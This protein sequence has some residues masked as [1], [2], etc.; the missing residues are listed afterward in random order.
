MSDRRTCGDCV[1]FPTCEALDASPS[2]PPCDFF[3]AARFDG[4][5]SFAAVEIARVIDAQTRDD[6]VSHLADDH[7]ICRPTRPC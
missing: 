6:A 3:A 5:R 4:D 7:A 1:R 2:D